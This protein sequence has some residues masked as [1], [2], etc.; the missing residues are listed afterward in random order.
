MVERKMIPTQR[1]GRHSHEVIEE[2][3]YHFIKPLTA[4]LE[5]GCGRDRVMRSLIRTP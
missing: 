5:K 4:L 2:L 3:R 1:L